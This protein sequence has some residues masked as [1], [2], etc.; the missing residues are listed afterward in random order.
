MRSENADKTYSEIL[1]SFVEGLT[2]GD[3]PDD[4]VAETKLHILDTL[5]V[6]L[7]SHGM[8]FSKILQDFARGLGG[9]PEST[10]VGTGDRLPAH[11]ASL[12]NATMV[13]GRDFDDMHREGSI[14]LSA[15]VVP[16]A[17]AVAEASGASG[18]AAMVGMVAGYEVGAR[19]GNA[20]CRKL[21]DRGWHPTGIFGAFTSAATAG[22]ILGS[23]AGQI[24]TAIGIA[25]SQCSGSAQWLEEDSWTKRIHPGWASHSGILAAKLGQ[26]GYN[27]P[28]KIFEG[29]KGIYRSYLNEGEF[30][31]YKITKELGEKWETREICYKIYPSGY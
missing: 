14:H 17:L 24:A 12:V 8:D 10:V 25:G 16:S 2:F 26:K 18:E 27:A 6:A 13:H 9:P 15:L 11:Y 29:G 21:L 20:A 7:A 5:G 22:K 4:V 23:T 3:I 28:R 1:A 30:D 31:L 19:I